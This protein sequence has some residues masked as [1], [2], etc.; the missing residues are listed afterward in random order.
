MRA[1]MAEFGQEQADRIHFKFRRAEKAV[2][3]DEA[4]KPVLLKEPG[5]KVALKVPPPRKRNGNGDGEGLKVIAGER[6]ER[7]AVELPG[8]VMSV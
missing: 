5:S 3:V 1:G 6:I 2:A 4:P 8:S 7:T